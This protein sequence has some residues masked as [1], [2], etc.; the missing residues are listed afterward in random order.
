M[1]R[2]NL[3]G[4]GEARMKKPARVKRRFARDECESSA[5]ALGSGGAAGAGAAASRFEYP[6]IFT[7]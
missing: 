1:P 3:S 2:G 7:Q 6:A 4:C 5:Q